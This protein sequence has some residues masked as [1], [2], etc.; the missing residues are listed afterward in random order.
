[1]PY[2]PPTVLSRTTA[3]QPVAQPVRQVVRPVVHPGH[4]PVVLS[5]NTPPAAF[6]RHGDYNYVEGHGWWPTWFPYWDS[7]WQAYWQSLYDYYGGDA[8]PDYAE[9]ARDEYMRALAAQQGWL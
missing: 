3:P 4:G 6:Q 8:N 7:T 2:R 5:R 9:Y 1:M